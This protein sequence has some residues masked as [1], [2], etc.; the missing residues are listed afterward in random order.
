MPACALST[1][2]LLMPTVVAFSQ[3]QGH[4][5]ICVAWIGLGQG[6]P[7]MMAGPDWQGWESLG[8]S[9]EDAAAARLHD[10][11]NTVPK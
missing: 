7:S 9:S 5:V 11:T 3:A 1:L 6:C 2:V 10:F 8:L 4:Q